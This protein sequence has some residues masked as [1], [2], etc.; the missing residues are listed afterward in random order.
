MP[1]FELVFHIE[2]NFLEV[3]FLFLYNLDKLFMQMAIPLILSKSG[4]INFFL[5]YNSCE[6]ALIINSKCWYAFFFPGSTAKH[7][8]ILTIY[9]NCSILI[10]YFY[11]SF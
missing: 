2:K 5:K 1:F 3:S 4:S 10:N 9:F 8:Q 11:S 6:K 7:V